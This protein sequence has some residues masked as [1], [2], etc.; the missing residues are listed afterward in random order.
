MSNSE[1]DVD[2][3]II[4]RGRRI[5]PPEDSEDEEG[6][7][8]DDTAPPFIDAENSTPQVDRGSNASATVPSSA[9]SSPLSLSRTAT[10]LGGQ[11]RRAGGV[12]AELSEGLRQVGALKNERKR[13][14]A[15]EQEETKRI[16]IREKQSTE[17]MS[18]QYYHE[19][20]LKKLQLQE[21]ELALRERASNLFTD[22]GVGN[23]H[24]EGSSENYN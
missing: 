5:T 22:F 16:D 18:L 21:R 2:I 12:V 4:S 6:T 14:A 1:N 15:C 13:A 7:S 24:G 17:R 23:E 9:R 20:E 10:P 8:D 11:R 3:D 19:I